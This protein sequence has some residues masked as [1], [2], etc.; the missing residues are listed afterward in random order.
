MVTTTYKIPVGIE[1]VN[2][3][4]FPGRGRRIILHCLHG[5]HLHVFSGTAPP[6][7]SGFSV[8]SPSTPSGPLSCYCPVTK[9]SCLCKMELS[10]VPPPLLEVRL[11]LSPLIWFTKV[12]TYWFFFSFSSNETKHRSW[13]HYCT[14][15]YLIPGQRQAAKYTWVTGVWDITESLA[16]LNGFIG[17]WRSI[18]PLSSHLMRLRYH[19][20]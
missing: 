8:N 4:Y 5:S 1:R 3:K 19:R 10:G 14:G 13:P 12:Y 6:G 7:S 17:K 15:L 16:V 9:R 11:N 18:L 20:S 2:M